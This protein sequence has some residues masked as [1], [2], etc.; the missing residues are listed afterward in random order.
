MSQRETDRH[1]NQLRLECSRT[2]MTI[3]YLKFLHIGMILQVDGFSEQINQII[4]DS[5]R[6]PTSRSRA[7]RLRA[8]LRKT[9]EEVWVS[10]KAGL[11]STDDVS[12]EELRMV[13]GNASYKQAVEPFINLRRELS[14]T[15]SEYKRA[16]SSMRSRQPAHYS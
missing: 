4:E 9:P 8:L 13:R 3:Q 16:A 10:L 12:K 7:M 5:Q 11:S 15:I 6:P 14:W 2:D 1:I